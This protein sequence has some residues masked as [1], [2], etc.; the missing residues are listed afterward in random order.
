MSPLK[1]LRRDFP[2]RPNYDR[3]DGLPG[4][5]YVLHNE[6]M[7]EGV[8]KIGQSTR[9]GQARAHDL[10]RT[11]GTET[12]KLFKCIFE[13]NT[14][15]C[16]RAEKAVHFRLSAHRMTKQEYFDVDIELAKTVIIEECNNQIL[17]RPLQPIVPPTP[18]VSF[19]SNA[20]AHQITPTFESP[21]V[22]QT[23]K[24]Y[25]AYLFWIAA[26]IG[27]ALFWP[28]KNKPSPAISYAP[29]ITSAPTFQ[30]NYSLAL[31]REIETTSP[32]AAPPKPAPLSAKKVPIDS[33]ATAEPDEKL[34]SSQGDLASRIKT[35]S[36]EEQ[37][38]LESACFTDKHRNGPA[39][40]NKCRE[41][42]LTA[43][44]AGTS[45]PN[46]AGLSTEEKS[47]LES[48]CFTDKHRNGPAAYN[49][50]REKQLTALQEGTPV[51][52]LAGLSREEKSSLESA[53]FTDKHRNG[54]AAYN[55]CREKQLTALQAG[56]SA[57]NL[58][59][60]STEEK[61]S[62]ESVCF[63]DKHRNGPAAYNKCREKRLA[64]LQK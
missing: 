9:S 6:A 7:R 44:Q 18:C 50:C 54:P 21:T 60:L 55:K 59:G 41:K 11:V 17:A 49:K 62:L 40:Y 53:C 63:T 45:A 64:D 10:N 43:L 22:T 23:S 30:P 2:Y 56:T 36:R 32:A 38:S 48:V 35:L 61:S 16:G 15:D 1:K 13:M 27:L 28:E 20:A 42:Q 34:P 24:S 5:V 46:L 52:N 31:K 33:Q 37:S 39:A 12:P 4:V 29:P 14:V 26:A 8:Y 25:L 57:P 58:A 47:S 3:N 51:P 19:E